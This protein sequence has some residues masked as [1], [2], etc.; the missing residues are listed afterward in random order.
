MRH[1]AAVQ[2]AHTARACPEPLEVG[3]REGSQLTT[4]GSIAS[5]GTEVLT[6]DHAFFLAKKQA[7]K[8]NR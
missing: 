8:E 3:A 6:V 7:D 4:T 5:P 2:A 1:R